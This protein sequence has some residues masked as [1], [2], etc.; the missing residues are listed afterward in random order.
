M[1]DVS[2]SYFSAIFD[3]DQQSF[4]LIGNRRKSEIIKQNESD[5]WILKFKNEKECLLQTN[6]QDED[7]ILPVG[8]RHWSTCNSNEVGELPI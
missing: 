7:D 6:F 3:K 8:R 1:V 2:D 5:I 4:K